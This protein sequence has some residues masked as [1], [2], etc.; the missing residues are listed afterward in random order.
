MDVTCGMGEEKKT[1][2]RKKKIKL[3]MKLINFAIQFVLPLLPSCVGKTV[4]NQCIAAAPATMAMIPTPSM[5]AIFSDAAAVGSG[6][7]VSVGFA[8]CTVSAPSLWLRGWD[9]DWD[10]TPFLS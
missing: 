2:E 8:V 4:S 5:F 10:H 7:P 1:K 3:N 6:A 9:W